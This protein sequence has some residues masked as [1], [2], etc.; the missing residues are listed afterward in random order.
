MA[1]GI[2]T[3]TCIA[4][5]Y[6]FQLDP[7]GGCL[8]RDLKS[9]IGIRPAMDLGP[10]IFALADGIVSDIRQ[11][12]HHYLPGSDFNRILDQC[13]RGDM[14]QMPRYG[15]LIPGH[16]AKQASGRLG[17]NGLDGCA[18]A[19]DTGSTVIQLSAMVEKCFGVLAIGCDKHALGPHIDPDNRTGLLRSGDLNFMGKKKEPLLADPLNL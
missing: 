18:G 11:V 15:S 10:E 1:A 19:P 6:R 13:L 14:Q 17:A 8:V 5:A 12:L 7:H 2:T 16:P 9:H 3:P 4:G